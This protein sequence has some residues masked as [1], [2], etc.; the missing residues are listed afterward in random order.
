MRPPSRRL[1]DEETNDG[2][3]TGLVFYEKYLKYSHPT[4]PV[5]FLTATVHQVVMRG[6]ELS[7]I[8][9]AISKFE[10]SPRMLPEIVRAIIERRI[11]TLFHTTL[12]ERNGGKSRP[13]ITNIQSE[14]K[15]YLSKHPET[16]YELS[17]RNFEFLVADIIK[18]LG[19]DVEVT[20]AT[21]DGGVD[22]YAYL[23]HEVGSFLML[24]EC[25]LRAPDRPVGI[26]VVQRLYGIQQTKNASKAM[27]V[28]T[29]FFTEPA[30]KEASQ[31]S[32][33]IDLKDYT[34]LKT[35]LARYS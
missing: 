5:L 25:K 12:E 10:T 23:R 1:S 31:L 21:R 6:L 26:D 20:K 13:I 27:I 18:D 28:T 3:R 22:I 29:S 34:T 8:C 4:T 35:W 30:R 2:S 15:R 33:I 16:I 19:M 17:P 7:P 32:G 11:E 24:I 9:K 14:I